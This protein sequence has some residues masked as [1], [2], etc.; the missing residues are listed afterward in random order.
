MKTKRINFKSNRVLF[1]LCLSMLFFTGFSYAQNKGKKEDTPT[2]KYSIHIVKEVNGVKTTIDTT[3]ESPD[4]FDVD[5]WV[6]RQNNNQDLESEK[7]DMDHKMKDFEKQIT[8]TIPNFSG[9]EKN[10]I[11]DTIYINNDT[12]VINAQLQEMLENHP[13][14]KDFGNSGFFDKHNEMPSPK[15][16]EK[17]SC[18]PMPGCPGMNGMNPFEGFGIQGL[19]KL[20]PLGNLEQIVIKKKRHGKKI[21]IN[22]EDNDDDIIIRPGRRGESYE[23]N[24]NSD[25]PSPR[26]S[27][28]K[29]VI[30]E[31][32]RRQDSRI[33]SSDDGNKKVIIIHK[34]VK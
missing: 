16:S 24:F 31:S 19:E 32:D 33:E 25:E 34:D 30:I 21:I 13:E 15:H 23:Y 6:E 14:W 2:Q 17:P 10:G 7:K 5:A 11:P 8:V 12:V 29:K 9:D 28:G 27:K 20:L 3:F 18:C 4:N 22:F 26:H 1:L